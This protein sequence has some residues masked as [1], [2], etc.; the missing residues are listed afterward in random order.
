M[1]IVLL[2]LLTGWVNQGADSVT[3]MIAAR[4][5]GQ[6]WSPDTLDQIADD[7]RGAGWEIRDPADMPTVKVNP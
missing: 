7:L 6:V 3:G 1:R 5:D 4:L 2:R